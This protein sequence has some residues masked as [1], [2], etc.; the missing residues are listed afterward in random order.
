[1]A[2]LF[3]GN[4]SIALHKSLST[5]CC[6]NNCIDFCFQKVTSI[7]LFYKI[8]KHIIKICKS[9]TVNCAHCVNHRLMCQK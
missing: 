6:N 4:T 3:T 8:F 2:A 1:M 7:R 5:M 9:K